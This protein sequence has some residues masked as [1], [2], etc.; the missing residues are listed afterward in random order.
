MVL[1]KPIVALDVGANPILIEHEVAGFLT[2]KGDLD[3][4]PQVIKYLHDNSDKAERIGEAAR[5][6]AKKLFSTSKF[7]IF[8]LMRINLQNL[9]QLKTWIQPLSA[10][11]GFEDLRRGFKSETFSRAVIEPV[12]DLC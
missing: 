12:F 7:K 10:T 6:R 11:L 8:I 9:L 2:P 3:S 4:L 5:E 1:C